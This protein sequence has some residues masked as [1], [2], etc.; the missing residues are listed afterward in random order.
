MDMAALLAP[1]RGVNFD[2]STLPGVLGGLRARAGFCPV[3][4]LVSVGFMER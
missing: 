4:E 3:Q 2:T 1:V